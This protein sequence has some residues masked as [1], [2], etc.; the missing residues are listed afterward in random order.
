MKYY[1][2]NLVLYFYTTNVDVMACHCVD[3]SMP[4][5]L[6]LDFVSEKMKFLMITSIN[7]S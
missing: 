3:L 6:Q 7:E 4:L 5:H 1:V 2:K